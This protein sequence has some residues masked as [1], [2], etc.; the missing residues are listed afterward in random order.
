MVD[1]PTYIDEEGRTVH[2]TEHP[3]IVKVEGL[4]SGRPVIEGT[5]FEA[6]DR[7]KRR[8]D[9]NSVVRRGDQEPVT[10]GHVLAVEP[11]EATASMAR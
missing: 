3:H 4:R 11:A 8:V 5:G 9:R 2:R 10:V 6:T 1:E 7:L